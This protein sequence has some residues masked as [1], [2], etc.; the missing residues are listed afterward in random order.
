ML[1]VEESSSGVGA[2][3]APT[4]VCP[5]APPCSPC[6]C[7]SKPDAGYCLKELAEFPVLLDGGG[8]AGA[9]QG[10]RADQGEGQTAGS[11]S[12]QAWLPLLAS[13]LLPHGKV[14]WVMR[15]KQ[16]ECGSCGFALLGA[17]DSPGPEGRLES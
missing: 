1:E 12:A 13:S 7:G 5:S 10:L 14:G 6:I 11:P 17:Q 2:A 8:E 16:M 3:P 9:S 15:E 4:S